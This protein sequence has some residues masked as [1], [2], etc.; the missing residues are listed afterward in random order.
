MYTNFLRF[1]DAR[2]A[3]STMVG[4]VVLWTVWMG[5]LALHRFHGL[6]FGAFDLGIFDQGLWLL[7][8]FEEPF[9][10]L[11]G[12]HLFADHASYILLVMVPIYWVL[13]HAEVL[14]VLCALIP[15]VAGWLSFVIARG[16]GLRPWLAVAAASAV[17]LAPAM[18]W[19]PW[20]AFHPETLAIVLFPA[21]FLA[22]TRKRYTLALVL[23]A[24]ILLVKEDSGLL[25]APF[26]LFWWFQ[27][28]EARNQAYVLAALAVGFQ[29]LSLLVILPGFSPTGELIYTGRYSSDLSTLLTWPRAEYLASILIPG[30]LAFWA[31]RVLLLGLP[32]TVANLASA[33]GYQHEILWHYT[34]YLLGV[35]A[36]AVPLGAARLARL[37]DD[38]KRPRWR[39]PYGKKGALIAAVWIAVMG[40]G[41]AGPDLIKR[42]GMWSG[43][44]AVEHAEV[45]RI[46]NT[47][48][49]EAV[50][51]AHWN[52]TPHLAHRRHVYMTPNPFAP[53]NWGVAGKYPPLHDPDTIEYL[54]IDTRRAVEEIPDLVDQLLA[55]GWVMDLDGTFQL[56]RNPAPTGTP[57]TPPPR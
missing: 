31:P 3:E 28:K 13:P 17:L 7:S 29:A 21:S 22:A 52:L 27:W 53:K 35:L 54:V 8:R 20:D 37:I 49:D 14:V 12:L 32:I 30:V 5:Y 38:P 44:S 48:P 43:L 23:A 9:I 40:L 36:V 26:A 1:I 50:V 2:R 42:F 33:H 10:T 55:E 24:L 4:I 57:G 56:F 34:A 39:F 19:T 51:S 46:L 16:E 45:G 41:L 6:G 25:I 47:I 15:A 11:R 18:V